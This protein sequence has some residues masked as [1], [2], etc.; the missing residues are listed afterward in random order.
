MWPAI[1]A[2]ED[3]VQGFTIK[4]TS[5][6]YGWHAVI[7]CTT[8][9]AVGSAQEAKPKAAKKKAENPAFAKVEDVAG[10]PRVLIIGDSI[11]IGYQVPLREDLKGKANVHR[12]AA[13]CGP[14]SRG[15][16]NIDSWLGDGKWDV[17]HFN[18]G[19][20]DIVFMDDKGQR[21]PPEKGGHHQVSESDY[22]KNLE[23]LVKRMKQTGAKLIF[24]TTTPVPPGSDGRT[25]NDEVK[26]NDIARRVMER[27]GVAIDDLYAFALPRLD[28]IQLPHNVHF[29]P[30]G[31]K[32]LA[33]QVAASILQALQAK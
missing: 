11:S 33:G 23:T 31:S 24:A 12:P 20:H 28:K 16:Q 26:Y 9:V 1:W 5:M 3:G 25:R 7:C 32:E 29:K 18:F 2:S 15:V 17:I 6:R 27:N 8:L 30:E 22:E 13:N 14:S 10:L 4:E 19:L 21:V